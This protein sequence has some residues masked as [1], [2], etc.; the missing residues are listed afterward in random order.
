MVVE[1]GHPFER[2]ELHGLL[3][4]PWRSAVNQLGLIESVDGLG[5]GVVITVALAATK[6]REVVNTSTT[7]RSSGNFASA[8]MSET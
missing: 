2:C 5:Q 4:L 8:Q 6:A 1:P 7:R 3:R